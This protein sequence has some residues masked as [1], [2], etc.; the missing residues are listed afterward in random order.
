MKK[1]TFLNNKGKRIL[2]IVSAFLLLYLVSYI[3]DPYSPCWKNYFTRDI[4]DI[5]IDWSI[6]LLFCFLVSETSIF[7]G[8]K[9]NRYIQW[10]EKPSR[11][12]LIETS[13][14]LLAVILIHLLTNSVFTYYYGDSDVSMVTNSIEK[15]RGDLQWLVVSTIIALMIMAINIGNYLIL[16]WKNEAVKTAELNQLVIEAELQSLKLQIDPHFVFNNLSVLSELI[17]ENQQLGYEYA[18]NFSKIY[19]YM[20]VNS[21]KD[22]ISLEDELKFLNSYMFL[23]KHRVGE[24]VS[25]CV[26]VDKESRRLSMPPLTL[27]LLVE[28]ALKHNKTSKKDPLQI[29][30]YNTDDCRLIVE[31]ALL[32]IEKPLNSSGIGIKNIIRRYKLLSE[33]EPEIIRDDTSFKVIIPLIKL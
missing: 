7:I 19:R 6:S 17:L 33:K 22:I 23:I 31:N 2:F 3:I 18:E 29:R 25:F 4:P 27:Q 20:L 1:D 28:N 8:L 5:I 21:K 13:L 24:G 26:E 12:L 16:N 9:L 30:I 15:N 32:P 11:R 10:T 14:N